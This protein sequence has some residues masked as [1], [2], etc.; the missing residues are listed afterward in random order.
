MSWFKLRRLQ[1]ELADCRWL[2]RF[3]LRMKSADCAERYA[4][5]IRR[6][7]SVLRAAGAE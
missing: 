1:V 7:R 2:L 4:D 6:L 5:R 3:A